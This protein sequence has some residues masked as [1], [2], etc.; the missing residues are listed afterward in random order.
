VP[1]QILDFEFTT[2]LERGDHPAECVAH[3]LH[4]VE[5]AGAPLVA[6]QG[7]AQ[8]CPVSLHGGGDGP[9]LTLLSA[10]ALA[11]LAMEGLTDALMSV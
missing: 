5:A 11:Q 9:V 7:L 8:R 10:P 4:A 3:G 2:W 1:V 6:T